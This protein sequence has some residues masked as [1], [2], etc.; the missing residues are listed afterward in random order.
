MP[1][2]NIFSISTAFQNLS[3]RTFHYLSITHSIYVATTTKLKSYSNYT[4]LGYVNTRA[5]TMST[6]NRWLVAYNSI[7]ASL[8]AIV[9]ANVLFLAPLL[10][11]PYVFDKTQ[12]FLTVVQCGAVVE[13]V[14]AVT[15]VVRLPVGTTVAQVFLRLLIVLGIFQLLPDSPANT[16]WAYISLCLAWSFTEVVR[17]SYYAANLADAGGV[18]YWLTWLRYSAFYVLYPI[19]VASEMSIIWMSLGEAELVVGKFYSWVLFAILFTYPPGLYSLYTYMMRQ[20]RKVLG[21]KTV[22]KE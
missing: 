19:G 7:S 10:G 2:A 17:Y 15:G 4:Q 22:K 6:P 20:R 3:N 5:T 14:N 13:I 11:Q 8:W 1:K 16:H 9:L 18:P 12:L 21:G